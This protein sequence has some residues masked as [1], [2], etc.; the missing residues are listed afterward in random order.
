MPKVKAGERYDFSLFNRQLIEMELANLS[1]SGIP[2]LEVKKD[3]IK[4]WNSKDLI[5]EILP[6]MKDL[7]ICLNG[8]K[9][10]RLI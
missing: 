6:L 9:R 1:L 2:N 3:I 7:R 4:N 8:L 5:G 10:F